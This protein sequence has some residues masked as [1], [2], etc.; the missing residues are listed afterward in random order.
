EPAVCANLRRKGRQKQQYPSNNNLT[1]SLNTGSCRDM[2]VL[3]PAYKRMRTSKRRHI[4]TFYCG[5]A[6]ATIL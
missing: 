6:E 4:A 5:T 3:F 2:H 1:A